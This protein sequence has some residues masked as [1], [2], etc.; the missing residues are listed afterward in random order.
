M[1]H[2]LAVD[3]AHHGTTPTRQSS[4]L[5]PHRIRHIPLHQEA[6][7]RAFLGALHGDA[8][9]VVRGRMIRHGV[10]K[11]QAQR[12]KVAAEVAVDHWARLYGV[13]V[14]VVLHVAMLVALQTVVQVEVQVAL[15]HRG[16]QYLAVA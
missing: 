13:A 10:G 12:V 5:Q 4:D 7:A 6:A 1:H 9:A 15:G 3:L 8:F 14:L 2:A 11:H 16:G